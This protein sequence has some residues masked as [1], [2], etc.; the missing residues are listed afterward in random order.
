[1]PER[2]SAITAYLTNRDRDPEDRN[3]RKRASE[4]LAELEAARVEAV[5]N[6]SHITKSSVWRRQSLA[7]H[8]DT[9]NLTHT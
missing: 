2:S 5:K 7:L 8:T 4:E 1:M 3:E 9:N 6:L